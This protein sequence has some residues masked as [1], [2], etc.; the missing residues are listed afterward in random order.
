MDEELFVYYGAA[1][2][3]IGVATCKL[4]DLVDWLLIENP[5]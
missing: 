5:L 1:D 2:K 4:D 3:T